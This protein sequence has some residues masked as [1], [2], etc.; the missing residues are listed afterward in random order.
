MLNLFGCSKKTSYLCNSK[1]NKQEI[2][3]N[4]LDKKKK[5]DVCFGHIDA[6]H[7]NL[8]V[9]HRVI[10][11]PEYLQLTYE[12]VQEQ[13]ND[14]CGKLYEKRQNEVKLL[15][16]AA[17]RKYDESDGLAKDAKD[18]SLLEH[19]EQQKYGYDP[20]SSYFDKFKY[21]EGCII[22]WSRIND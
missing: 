18:F 4:M 14:Y 19:I 8:I 15:Y 11:V 3:V 20:N 7:H 6:F 12:N 10:E 13:I 17:K 16:E 22:S 9:D 21:P 1:Y 5:I 2:S